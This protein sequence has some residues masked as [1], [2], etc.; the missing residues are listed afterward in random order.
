[1]KKFKKFAVAIVLAAL[2]AFSLAFTACG[3]DNKGADGGNKNGVN[4]EGGNE[5]GNGGGADEKSLTREQIYTAYKNVGLTMLGKDI[6]AANARAGIVTASAAAARS[7]EKIP[8]I[9]DKTMTEYLYGLNTM[10]VTAD[11]WTYL[12]TVGE[13][14]IYFRVAEY[15]SA[16]RDFEIGKWHYSDTSEYA[17]Y[18]A[19]IKMWYEG[20]DIYYNFA[21]KIRDAVKDPDEGNVYMTS[22][23]KLTY[24]FDSGDYYCTVFMGE[25]DDIAGGLD[26]V[27]KRSVFEF[28]YEDKKLGGYFGGLYVSSEGMAYDFTGCSEQ[29]GTALEKYENGLKISEKEHNALVAQLSEAV[30]DNYA[31]DYFLAVM[32][33]QSFEN[34]LAHLLAGKKALSLIPDDGSAYSKYI[35]EAKAE[36]F[37]KLDG[38]ENWTASDWVYYNPN[39]LEQKLW[40]EVIQKP[41][42]IAKYYDDYTGGWSD[43]TISVANFYIKRDDDVTAVTSYEGYYKDEACTQPITKE[44]VKSFKFGESTVY[45][46]DIKK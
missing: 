3:T 21:V 19:Y 14:S 36:W 42:I 11:M 6:S 1:M 45:V 12:F 28:K 7:E 2:L 16:Q 40:N 29:T 22:Y 20:N 39:V 24:D 46:K 38:A 13:F 31:R 8:L 41:E 26:K 32:D 4:S 33:F 43:G 17:Y 44:D 25:T 23:S 9:F 27:K 18:E 30:K 34:N 5:S 10:D 15:C 35:A 37:E